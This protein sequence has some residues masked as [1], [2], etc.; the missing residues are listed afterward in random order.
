MHGDRIKIKRVSVMLTEMYVRMLT[1][2][3]IQQS[4]LRPYRPDTA[5]CRRAFCPRYTPYQIYRLS[6]SPPCPD[7]SIHFRTDTQKPAPI[8]SRTLTAGRS[9]SH[10]GPFPFSVKSR[11]FT[12]GKLGV[13]AT[14]C[15]SPI[16]GTRQNQAQRLR[17]FHEMTT[18]S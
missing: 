9:T 17:F 8:L 15:T 2:R 14:P 16:D 10:S 4:T 13:R 3:T 6:I 5:L 11:L 7:A 12:N 1:S 18:Y